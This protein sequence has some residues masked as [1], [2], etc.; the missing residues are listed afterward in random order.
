MAEVQQND[1]SGLVLALMIVFMVLSVLSVA[2]R[3]ISRRIARLKLWWD[4][5]FVIA[6]LV[7]STISP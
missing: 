6:S 3:L 1:V 4:D 2:L 7:S 5:Y